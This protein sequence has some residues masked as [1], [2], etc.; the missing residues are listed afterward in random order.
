MAFSRVG[1]YSA[2]RRGIVSFHSVLFCARAG[3]LDK[4]RKGRGGGSGDGGGGG[5]GRMGAGVK[6]DGRVTV[7]SLVADA[8]ASRVPR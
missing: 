2:D 1:V 8:D 4:R 3:G 5:V 7:V 6:E